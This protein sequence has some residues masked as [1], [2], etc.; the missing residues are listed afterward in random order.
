MKAAE[1]MDISVEQSSGEVIQK[2]KVR[3]LWT[4]GS[5]NTDVL[6][7]VNEE[8]LRREQ[9][10]MSL[11]NENQ[12]RNIRCVDVFSNWETN[13]ARL[14][15]AELRSPGQWVDDPLENFEEECVVAVSA[16]VC[17]VIHLFCR[18]DKLRRTGRGRRAKAAMGLPRARVSS[19]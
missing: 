13:R 6:S 12:L 19:S 4:L 2:M 1:R 18:C 15:S 8:L 11:Y 10:K 16:L 5:E 9:M 7:Q 14:A 17:A 3:R